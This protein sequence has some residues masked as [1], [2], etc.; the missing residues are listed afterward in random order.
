[1]GHQY[2]TRPAHN[3][4]IAHFRLWTIYDPDN[5]FESDAESFM[6]RQHDL[7]QFFG[8][9]RLASGAN[10]DPLVLVLDVPRTAN[11][12]GL[13]RGRQD[14]T[15]GQTMGYEASGFDLDLQLAD[16]AAEN[17]DTRNAGHAQQA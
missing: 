12:R 15:H 7:A 6:L 8:R 16:F 2:D 9:E 1:M 17:L 11:A 3:Q 5:V 14:V 10:D 13:A 4:A